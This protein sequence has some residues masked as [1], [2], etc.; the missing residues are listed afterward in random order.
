MGGLGGV[1]GKLQI[2]E[3]IPHPTEV[4]RAR[5]MPQSDNIIATKTA[6]PEVLLFDRRTTGSRKRK[7]DSDPQTF[8][9]RKGL[10]EMRLVGHEKEGY[11]LSWNPVATGI[12]L[13]GAD[14]HLVCLWD[15]NG[16]TRAA[17]AGSSKN[18]LEAKSIFRGHTSIVGDVCWHH[19]HEHVFASVGDDELLLL[20]DDRQ[21]KFTHSVHA[22]KQ[23]I[24]AVSF[25]LCE[26]HL[27]AT[28]SVDKTIGLWDIRNLKQKLH[29]FEGH[30][31]QI[32]GV[33]WAPFSPS[34][35]AS[36]STDRRINVWDLTR[37]GQEQSPE[38]AEDGPPE[39][40]F[41][42]AGHTS[43]ISDFSWNPMQNWVIA[44]VAENNNL[45]VWQMAECVYADD[46]AP[47]DENGKPIELE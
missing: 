44:S 39:L 11:G 32:V 20:W 21:P 10:N 13:S 2:V 19:A 36:C 17:S 25:N 38:D 42:H 28:G 5:A 31:Q 4:N 24:N 9:L 41:A 26:E 8:E 37:I 22:H 3:R 14:D 34:V 1:N 33:Q 7:N 12:L 23:E 18:Q 6:G 40:L 15:I 43:K 30:A 27:L 46:E 16:L 29:S 45:Q 35:L 47:A